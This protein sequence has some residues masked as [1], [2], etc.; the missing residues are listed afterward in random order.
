MRARFTSAVIGSALVTALLS[1]RAYL[2]FTGPHAEPVASLLVLFFLL[3][4]AFLFVYFSCWLISFLPR[5]WPAVVRW[6]AIVVAAVLLALSL[7]FYQFI[8]AGLV[9][10]W[11]NA[12][13]PCGEIGNR[14]FNSLLSAGRG[15]LIL[16][17]LPL[18]TAPVLLAEHY[19]QGRRRPQA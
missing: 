5:H 3:A 15:I 19:L 2:P 17:S 8:P 9:F 4:F 16:L 10:G 11:C 12:G 13:L 14:V 1:T 6:L 7:G 18:V